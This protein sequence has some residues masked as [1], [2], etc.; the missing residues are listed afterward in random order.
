M[1]SK[2]IYS[3]IATVSLVGILIFGQT[4]L[5]RGGSSRELGRIAEPAIVH[6]QTVQM[7]ADYPVYTSPIDLA[8]QSTLV[9]QGTVQDILPAVRIL[10]TGVDASQ[11]PPSKAD[12]GYFVTDVVIKVNQVLAGVLTTDTLIVTYLGGQDEKNKITYVVEGEPTAQ[13]GRAYVLFLERK[14]DGKYVILGGQ[15]GHY[16]FESG[17]LTTVP[18]ARQ[19]Y[20][21]TKDLD[22]VDLETLQQKIKG[23]AK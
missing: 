21:V 17:K 5:T 3:V 8:N 19:E 16:G 13:K 22:G 12:A 18:G 10:P 4:L 9:V 14:Q 20:Q 11:L 15:Q 7:L 1:K 6:T 23:K 2:L